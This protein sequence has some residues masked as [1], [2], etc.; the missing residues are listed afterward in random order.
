[1]VFK[2]TGQIQFFFFFFFWWF[3]SSSSVSWSCGKKFNGFQASSQFPCSK[4]TINCKARMTRVCQNDLNKNLRA[5]MTCLLNFSL[6]GFLL[7]LPDFYKWWWSL[8]LFTFLKYLT[9]VVLC[10]SHVTFYIM[11]IWHSCLLIFFS[12]SFISIFLLYLFT[13]EWFLT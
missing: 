7:T 12:Q 11:C 6:T 2:Y 4:F 3:C 5:S 10:K 13:F 1:M 9:F 8:G